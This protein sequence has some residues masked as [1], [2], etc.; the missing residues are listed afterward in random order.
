VE[1]AIL[2]P[3][4]ASAVLLARLSTLATLSA[5]KFVLSRP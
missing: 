4:F 5:C 2:D 3:L 1:P